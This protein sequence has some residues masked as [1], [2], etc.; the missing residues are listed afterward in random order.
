MQ[1]IPLWGRG[2]ARDMHGAGLGDTVW[3]HDDVDV[4]R[5]AC[6]PLLTYNSLE[7]QRETTEVEG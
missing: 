6:D 4:Q 7:L 3:Y 2:H 5:N 1:S